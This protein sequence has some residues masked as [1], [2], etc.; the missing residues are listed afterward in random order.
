MSPIYIIRSLKKPSKKINNLFAVLCAAILVAG[1]SKEPQKT[2]YVARVND[3]YLTMEEL[4]NISDTMTTGSNFYKSE[5]IRNWID[6]ELLYQ[7]AVN[8]GVIKDGEFKRIID[9]SRKTLAGAILLR[10]VSE[11][12]DVDYSDN[13][14]DNFFQS[15]KNEFKL[16]HD[17]YFVN[18]MEF[19][20]EDEAIEFRTSVL[21]GGW[22]KAIESE[23]SE[24]FTNEK[25]Q[26]LLNEDEIYPLSLRNILV[27]L[28]QEEVSIVINPDSS[29]FMI[30]QLLDKYPAGTVPPFKFVK[31]KIENSFVAFE[32][33][34]I[35]NEYIKRLYADNDIEVKN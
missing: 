21:E 3:S 18:M 10:R 26:I 24:S 15:H 13:D 8:E 4:N 12:Y 29:T 11:K 27:E 16:T 23:K 20:N 32:K 35:I 7:Q 28:Y 14:L 33:R 2:K 22:G 19:K 34:K 1:C 5:I 6:R 17:A 31:K 25:S 30:V 9:E